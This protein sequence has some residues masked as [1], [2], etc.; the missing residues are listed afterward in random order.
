MCKRKKW[1]RKVKLKIIY[2]FSFYSSYTVLIMSQGNRILKFYYHQET[3]FQQWKTSDMIISKF[4]F[5][6]FFIF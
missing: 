4:Y 2:V 5:N 6:F 1:H 3:T